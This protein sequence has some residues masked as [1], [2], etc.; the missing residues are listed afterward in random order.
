MNVISIFSVVSNNDLVWKKTQNGLPDFTPAM[1]TLAVERTRQSNK[2]NFL[3]LCLKG[4]KY[5]IYFLN[6][7]RRTVA[8]AIAAR[9]IVAGSGTGD[10]R[11]GGST[12]SSYCTTSLG[13]YD[14]I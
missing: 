9:T 5:G 3:P 10:G 7:L 6:T 13:R 11:S 12:G 8:N 14:T 1:K 4:I 2:R